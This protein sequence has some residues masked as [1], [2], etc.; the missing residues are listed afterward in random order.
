MASIIRN[1]INESSNGLIRVSDIESSGGDR[2]ALKKYVEDNSIVRVGRGLYQIADQWEDEL[3]ILSLKYS[4]GIISHETALYIHGFTDRTPSI[5]T[6]TFP[7]GYNAPSLKNENVQI[8]RVKKENY[9]LGIIDGKSFYGNP[10]RL[11]NIERTLC[12]I[13]R[14]EGSDIQIVLDAMKR[15]AKYENKNINLLF[16]YAEQLHVKK[17]ILRYMEILL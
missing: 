16:E 2:H 13:V 9:N 15:Y 3:Y 6:L 12:D 8:K 17:K 4:R 7:R 1:M 10:V 14:G 5:Y 11:Y